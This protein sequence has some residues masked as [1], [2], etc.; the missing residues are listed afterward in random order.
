MPNFLVLK[1]SVHSIIH[2]F[3]GT[4]RN[5][6]YLIPEDMFDGLESCVL[7]SG[8]YSE[9]AAIP[10]EIFCHNW[11]C[12]KKEHVFKDFGGFHQEFRTRDGIGM[13][14]YERD[15][16]YDHAGNRISSGGFAMLD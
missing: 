12:Q 4:T 8:A 1:D 7:L 14:A 15:V 5:H 11:R 6:E 2:E 13:D 10:Q 9:Y 16:P 3:Q